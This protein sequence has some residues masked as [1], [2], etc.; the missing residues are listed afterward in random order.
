LLVLVTGATG[1]IGGRLV[2]LLLER[3]FAVRC[4]ARSASKLRDVPW[5]DR[6]EVVEGDVLDSPTLSSYW[7]GLV[8]PVPN[9]I[10]RPLVES[11]R[12]EVV[13]RERDLA[14]YVPDPPDGL[15][16]FDQAVE[17]ALRR[18]QEADVATRWSSTSWP[19]EP[20]A[21]LPTDPDWAGGSLYID[22]R[23]MPVA[24]DTDRL[25]AV[26]EGIG[27]EH[28]WY[29][30]GLAWRLRGLL[31]RLAGGAGLR[32][33][34]RDPNH[35]RVGDSLDFWRVEELE[36]RRLLRL[37]AEMRLPGLAWLEFGI[38]GK[39]SGRPVLTQRAIFHP[40]GLIG[41]LYWWGVKPFHGIVFG[42][43]LRNIALAAERAG[44][45]A[46]QPTRKA[47]GITGRLSGKR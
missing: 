31:D 34:R 43:M 13:I 10:A 46:E 28:G 19:A 4:L 3:G 2:P 36:P 41:Q 9:A 24:T 15:V 21:P 16:G 42:G 26:V 30:W 33:G 29:S 35:L 22:Q 1:Y 32:R 47:G 40:H 38:D 37:R 12:N 18:V 27:G 8:T 44:A 45:P 20:S 23:A 39:R 11:L 17:L 6:V 7:V 5:R 14:G 25:W